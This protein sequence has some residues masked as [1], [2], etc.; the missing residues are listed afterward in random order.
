MQ[1]TQYAHFKQTTE[2]NGADSAVDST[3]ATAATGTNGT[4]KAKRNKA[5]D[6]LRALAI[7]GVVLYHMRPSL[8]KG[9]FIGV[10]AFFVLTGYLITRS[11]MRQNAP[12]HHFSYGRYLLRRLTRLWP[13]TLVTI[14][15]TA[16]ITFA[17]SPSLLPKVQTDALPA[18]FFFSNWSYI[19]RKVS[20]FAAAGLPSPLTHLWFLG[21][22]MQFYIVWPVVFLLL[23]RVFKKRNPMG[24]A[25]FALAV[26][27]AVAMALLFDPMGDTARVYYGA[28]TRA[29]E[30]LVGA[31]LAIMLPS[32]ERALRI[33]IEDEQGKQ[34]FGNSTYA[35]FAGTAALAALVIGSV[36]ARGED[37]WLY[38]G[39]FFCIAIVCALLIATLEHPISIPS[40]L[41]SSKPLTYLGSRS[42]SIYL[43]HYPLLIV[44][45]PATRTT[46][47]PW[48][49]FV[50]EI[51]IV[52]V[53]GE[54]FYRL[55]EEPFARKEPTCSPAKKCTNAIACALCVVSVAGVAALAVAPVNWAKVSQA[56]AEQLRPELAAERKAAAKAAKQQR[57]AQ[58]KAAE[59][60]QAKADA[61]EEAKRQ[62]EEQK[63]KAEKVPKNLPW[64]NWTYDANAGTC[65]ADVLMIGDSVTAGAAPVLSK[66]L[67][68]S[69]IDG[70]VSRQMWTGP[71]V[72]NND[73]SAGHNT[74]TVI[75]A[76]G[77]NCTI[78]DKSQ[79]QKLVDTVQGKPM[80]FVTIRAPL[81]LQDVNNQ[82]LREVAK[83]NDNVGIID[84][85]GESEGHSE[86]LV[87][88]GIHLT[89]AGQ[90]AYAAM[91]RRALCGR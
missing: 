5:L 59:E 51:L 16:G 35:S 15:L 46:A 26:A 53:A 62:E 90:Q 38:Q 86:Y 36:V 41:L 20:Y 66:V 69:F 28:D 24:S 3:D 79:V 1:E 82:I 18:A 74:S 7:V 43:M 10:T 71:D 67:P 73:I 88:D 6:G 39:G 48:W 68:N 17:V 77:T 64:K 55:V 83:E 49:G 13:A 72:Y 45:N 60:A 25:T 40:K 57:L 12:E 44:M 30:L 8:L 54:A 65:S 91:I 37:I 75:F 19:F 50:L 31:A 70:K 87:D 81:D 61:Q 56:R 52:L 21:V 85:H 34:R 42:F 27:S 32:I 2:G 78:R 29:A 76:L 58:K 33:H 80:Y 11:I 22:E 63:P 14:V 47:L 89:S 9:G 4:S 84:W 23:T